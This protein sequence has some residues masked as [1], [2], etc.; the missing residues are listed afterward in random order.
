MTAKP[1]NPMKIYALVGLTLVAAVLAYF[2]LGRRPAGSPAAELSDA[3][4]D[5]PAALQP[6]D[7]LVEQFRGSLATP[8]APFVPLGRDVFAPAPAVLESLLPPPPPPPP[9]PGVTA[10]VSNA[11]A[12][13]QSAWRLKGIMVQRGVA[14]AIL[15][16][17]LVRAGDRVGT[18]TV[19]RVGRDSVVLRCG[20]QE[21][22]V[23]L[24]E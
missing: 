9:P 24:S 18:C 12:A 15:N 23:R 22:V 21:Q 6:V 5:P 19:V 20:T 14:T 13:P 17:A 1:A 3:A 16:D 8:T 7:D 11:P 4:A 2:R 10:V